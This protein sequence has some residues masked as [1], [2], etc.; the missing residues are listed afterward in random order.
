MRDRTGKIAQ[1]V[2]G[3]LGC[4]MSS[5]RIGCATLGMIGVGGTAGRVVG[6]LAGRRALL[7]VGVLIAMSSRILCEYLAGGA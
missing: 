4:Q 7:G 6:H 3:D 2:N 1:V 5:A